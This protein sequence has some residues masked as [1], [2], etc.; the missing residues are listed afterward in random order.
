[1]KWKRPSQFAEALPELEN[2]TA[3]AGAGHQE[4]TRD[5]EKTHKAGRGKSQ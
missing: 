1:M 4:D 2:H 5:V 3:L